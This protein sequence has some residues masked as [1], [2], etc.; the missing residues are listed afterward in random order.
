MGF[1]SRVTG[2]FKAKTDTP[3]SGSIFNPTDTDPAF[4]ESEPGLVTSG[5]Q[6]GLAPPTT[7]T[8][9]SG[10]I[11]RT[12]GTSGGGGSGTGAST[13]TS[14]EEG[15]VLETVE[16]TE[17]PD[18]QTVQPSRLE[19][20][21]TYVGDYIG[22][23]PSFGERVSGSVAGFL[24]RK[25]YDEP[26]LF[27]DINVD[28]SDRPA[29]KLP[30]QTRGTITTGVPDLTI[31]EFAM[32]EKI[33]TRGYDPVPFVV[34][35]IGKGL[36]VE[37]EKGL[38]KDFDVIQSKIDSGKLTLEEGEDLLAQ[39]TGAAE[40]KLNIKF[41]K[42][43]STAL[44]SRAL[45]G[46]V[47][48]ELDI[49]TELG[50]VT[51]TGAIVGGMAVA[52]VA[53][54]T[55][56]AASGGFDFIKGSGLAVGGTGT[57]TRVMG[58]IQAGLGL[59]S[60]AIGT[61]GAFGAIEKQVDLITIKN[62]QKQ[63]EKLLGYERIR[64]SEGSV[65]EIGTL[66]ET[67]LGKITTKQRIPV[68]KTDIPGITGTTE[69][70][71][72]QVLQVGTPRASVTGGK[73]IATL[74][75]FSVRTGGMVTNQIKFGTFAQIYPSKTAPRLAGQEIKGFG[76]SVGTGGIVFD[77]KI[78]PIKFAGVG[79][80]QGE[81]V[82]LGTGRVSGINI[83]TPKALFKP[84]TIGF[85]KRVPDVSEGK[86]FRFIMGTG[87]GKSS[88][89]GQIYKQDMNILGGVGG[90]TSETTKQSGMELVKISKPLTSK[91]G[92]ISGIKLGT[93]TKIDS[94]QLPGLK[95]ESKQL[96]K[97][98]SGAWLDE[99]LKVS[100]GYDLLSD[101]KTKDKI[102]TISYTGTSSVTTSKLDQGLNVGL[103]Q[104]LKPKSMT[105]QA[106]KTIG[107]TAPFI[108]P[109]ITSSSALKGFKTPPPF[110]PKL[111]GFGSGFGM[112]KVKGK[113]FKQYVPSFRALVFDIKGTK[114]KG[115]K[116]PSGKNVLTGF[117]LRPKIKKKKKRKKKK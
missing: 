35:D 17:T 74:D 39:R 41:E 36:K 71:I 114:P 14:V 62:I 86:G 73:G 5:T 40:E 20:Y 94:K 2:G 4:K 87:G 26:T 59:T 44:A 77:T 64:T 98:R 85:I 12:G 70:G 96:K 93:T 21:E 11:T 63:Q 61:R 90:L 3:T 6:G 29:T 109:M 1:W 30:Y 97:G 112:G 32:G 24:G 8:S 79:K 84:E 91:T 15:Q 48:T 7:T 27:S 83:N 31:G 53:T 67:P 56:L 28:I 58:G 42:D 105:K 46:S 47:R 75:Y 69:S 18:T 81:L 13:S 80:Q 38:Q 102:K 54:G 52:P 49:G 92:M 111:R 50:L 82:S 51:K 89:L 106:S 110:I 43:V 37:A 66:K 45:G 60:V 95:L 103:T 33:A 23:K 104:G 9:S 116:L 88:G 76:G 100:G 78:Q 101:T 16:V 107:L 115:I 22:D 117:E 113:Q 99:G 34:E 55:A 108:S 19:P 68:F 72:K 10:G 65:Y 57:K 25:R